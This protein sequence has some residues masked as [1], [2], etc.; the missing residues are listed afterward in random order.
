MMHTATLRRYSGKDYYSKTATRPIKPTTNGIPTVRVTEPASFVVEIKPALVVACA[1]SVGEG[2]LVFFG[3][4]GLPCKVIVLGA[5]GFGAG[6]V[7]VTQSGSFE[8]PAGNVATGGIPVTTP[9]ASVM[10]K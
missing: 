7:F 8:R 4:A 2:C 6:E 1:A 3:G 5:A 9:F 10:V